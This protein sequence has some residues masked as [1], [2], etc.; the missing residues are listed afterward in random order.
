[1]WDIKAVYILLA[2][3]LNSHSSSI[4]QIY[5]MFTVLLDTEYIACLWLNV[6]PPPL[7]THTLT[8]LIITLKVT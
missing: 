6:S 8:F 1:M 7:H 2:L 5:Y 4:E 3:C